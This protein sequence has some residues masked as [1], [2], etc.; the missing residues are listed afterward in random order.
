MTKFKAKTPKSDASRRF[1]DY[2]I[3]VCIVFSS[4]A[5]ISVTAISMAN[6]ALALFKPE[7]SAKI[8]AADVDEL[9]KKLGEEQIIE[10]PWL[11]SAYV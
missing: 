6:D 11:F 5:V 4:T 8:S 9:A 1:F 7:H 10:H 2:F 3:L